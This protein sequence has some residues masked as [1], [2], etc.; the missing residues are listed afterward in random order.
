MNSKSDEALHGRE[1]L[2]KKHS[3]FLV[4]KQLEAMEKKKRVISYL[5]KDIDKVEEIMTMDNRVNII[6]G[7]LRRS[8][9]RH[10]SSQN[11]IKIEN[12]DEDDL[13]DYMDQQSN[14]R[15]REQSA[16]KEV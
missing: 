15:S 7:N 13:G 5:I 8:V 12:L 9:N 16:N 4:Q 3:H 14:F 2:N 11:S 10:N 1:K 6:R